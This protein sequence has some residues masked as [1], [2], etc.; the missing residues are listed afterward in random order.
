MIAVARMRMVQV[1]LHQ[2]IDVVAVRHGFMTAIRSMRVPG[3]VSSARMAA[4]TH[5]RIA[6]ADLQ[7]V[8]V[9][10]IAMRRVQVAI[11]KIIDMI[12]MLH[13][14]VAA[15]GTMDM[16]MILVNIAG[17]NYPFLAENPSETCSSAL[18]TSSAMWRSASV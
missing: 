8:L 2:V 11:V 9:G 16:G 13:S 18:P 1:A 4:G 12:P 6:R 3:G 10:V 7:H 5:V 15:A 17:H 14:R